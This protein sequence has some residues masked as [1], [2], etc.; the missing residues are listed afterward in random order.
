MEWIKGNHPEKTK[1]TG[2]RGSRKALV[3]KQV[4]KKD[5]SSYK[6]DY[7]MG[8]RWRYGDSGANK[9]THYMW[10]KDPKTPTKE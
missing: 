6:K 10:I 7:W 4:H 8:D 1:F 5:E 3:R 2:I 9:I